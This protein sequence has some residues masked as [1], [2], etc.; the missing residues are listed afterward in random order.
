MNT[1]CQNTQN[2]QPCSDESK[3]QRR[4]LPAVETGCSVG[5]QKEPDRKLIQLT[6]GQLAIVDKHDFEELNRYKWHATAQ[7]YAVRRITENG[8]Q[9]A[10]YMHRVILKTP[11]GM[12]TDHKNGNRLDNRR[13]NL[14]TATRSQNN[15]NIGLRRVNRFGMKG[16]SAETQRG[17]YRATIMISKVSHYLGSFKTPEEAYTVY[18]EAATRLH[19]EFARLA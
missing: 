3:P 11:K 17:K 15:H 1:I 2:T 6:R 4:Q 19:G 7:G 10:V 13:A 14:R 16:V 9:L 5:G 8:K 18:C 12:D